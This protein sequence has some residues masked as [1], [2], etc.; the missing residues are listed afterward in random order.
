MS[1]A[2]DEKNPPPLGGSVAYWDRT[3]DP[4]HADAFAGVEIPFSSVLVTIGGGGIKV[5]KRR[6][7]WMAYDWIHNPIGW[8][9]DGE[10]FESQTGA[11]FIEPGGYGTP[12]AY[13]DNEHGR[14]VAAENRKYAQ[15][16]AR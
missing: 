2:V 1:Y 8:S 10:V 9:A 11:F 13:L 5:G 7:G 12:C 14:A 4:F 6:D 16:S 15:E 3:Q